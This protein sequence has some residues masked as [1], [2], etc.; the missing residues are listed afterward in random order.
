MIEP[1]ESGYHGLPD[2][3]QGLQVSRNIPSFYLFLSLMLG[4]HSMV[5]DCTLAF[6]FIQKLRRFRVPFVDARTHVVSLLLTL[7]KKG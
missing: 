5:Y 6:N 2:T 1:S 7:C 4:I 3:R